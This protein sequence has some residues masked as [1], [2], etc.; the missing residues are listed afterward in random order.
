MQPLNNLKRHPAGYQKLSDSG[1]FEDTGQ[2]IEVIEKEIIFVEGKGSE[3]RSNGPPT[4]AKIDSF[5]DSR[6]ELFPRSIKPKYSKQSNSTIEAAKTQ[7]ED[8]LVAEHSIATDE[9][10]NH[11]IENFEDNHQDTQYFISSAGLHLDL[12][13]LK[14]NQSIENT[15]E[16]NNGKLRRQDSHKQSG[17]NL[18]LN[19][20]AKEQQDDI[21][22][23]Y[24]FSL[25]EELSQQIVKL[26]SVNGQLQKQISQLRTSDYS[27]EKMRRLEEAMSRLIRENDSLKKESEELK[28]ELRVTMENFKR[29]HEEMI[30]DILMKHSRALETAKKSFESE[31][32]RLKN[33]NNDLMAKAKRCH[34]CQQGLLD[35]ESPLERNPISVIKTPQGVVFSAWANRKPSKPRT[36]S[37]EEEEE[38]AQVIVSPKP[39]SR[40]KSRSSNNGGFYCNDDIEDFHTYLKETHGVESVSNFQQQPK[41]KID[42]SQPKHFLN[43]DESFSIM[44]KSKKKSSRNLK[45]DQSIEFQ[46]KQRDTSQKILLNSRQQFEKDKSTNRVTDSSKMVHKPSVE[47][48]ETALKIHKSKTKPELLNPYASIINSS[49][50]K[51]K[52]IDQP[53]ASKSKN[54]DRSLSKKSTNKSAKKS[55]RT[56]NPIKSRVDLTSSSGWKKD[57]HQNSFMTNISGGAVPGFFQNFSNHQ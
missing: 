27:Q 26:N 22:H 33:E 12:K 45:T 32:G 49:K 29:Y 56:K 42:N 1:R 10:E 40:S 28:T 46:S 24:N 44:I 51:P 4:F 48:K 8:L 3:S 43:Q 9:K 2:L 41:I 13:N 19:E 57:P 34:M 20:I 38:P 7:S 55:A 18:I 5:K 50:I 6:Q 15:S 25:V 35:R 47:K 53:K 30:N 54:R 36:P 37:C 14:L 21:V 52:P 11:S 31:V 16:R 23:E 17:K 39:N